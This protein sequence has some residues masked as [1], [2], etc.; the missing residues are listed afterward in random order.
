MCIALLFINKTRP[1]P[2]F[3]SLISRLKNHTRFCQMELYNLKL[4]KIELQFDLICLKMKWYRSPAILGKN[5]SVLG[6]NMAKN[7]A[8]FRLCMLGAQDLLYR[9]ASCWAFYLVSV[10]FETWLFFGKK[11]WY[12]LFRGRQCFQSCVRKITV[13]KYN[14]ETK[15]DKQK[16]QEIKKG[17]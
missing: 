14:S 11:N 4:P 3:C 10:H 8:N 12:E 15:V 5:H 1:I 13:K 2:T 16:L 17:V 6:F 7:R 9:M